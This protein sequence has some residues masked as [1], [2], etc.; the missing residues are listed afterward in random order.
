VSPTHVAEATCAPCHE[1]AALN[2]KYG[3]PAGRLASFVDSYHGVKSKAGDATVANC[4]SCH[5]AHR[6]LPSSDPTSSIAADNLAETCG[7]CHPGISA[8]LAQTR[9]HEDGTGL[10]A[11]LPRFF[12]LAYTVLIVGV[13]GFMVAYCA[14]DFRRHVQEAERH[15]TLRRMD[16]NAIWQHGLLTVSFI[17]L[18][19]TG[20]ALRYSEHWPFHVIFGWD[21]GYQVRGTVH[22]AAAALFLFDC[23]W[24]L[25]YLRTRNGRTFLRA[26]AFSA[27]DLRELRDTI[28]YNLGRARRRPKP[29]TFGHA[30]KIEYWALV[31]GAVIMTI[32]GFFLWF[33]NLAIRIFHKGILDIMLVIHFYEA[34]LATLAVAIWHSYGT[35]FSP[36]VYP[37][38][39][40]WLTGRAR[41][42]DHGQ[43][44]SPVASEGSGANENPGANETDPGR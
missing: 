33:D 35:V 20:F 10:R 32:T 14:V 19:V 15:A 1:S 34:V 9:I 8:S 39:F 40:A 3:L 43:G 5:G 17:T 21:G 28:A 16:A 11:G 24:H 37:G 41:G 36:A 23:F 31:W 44:E 4:A 29:G 2:E 25:I 38:N 42:H 7:T 6:I 13:I 26:M 22:R 30:E 12:A 18:I 27:G